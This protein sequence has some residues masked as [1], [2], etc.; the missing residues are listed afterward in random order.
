MGR[1]VTISDGKTVK[2]GVAKATT[3]PG[4]K[5]DKRVQVGAP[6]WARSGR[7]VR[8]VSSNVSHIKYDKPRKTMWV[9]FKSGAEYACPDFPYQT[10]VAYFNASSMGQYHW[11]LR[12]QGY[13]FKKM[14]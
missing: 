13:V 6:E 4:S 10:A 12:K 1:I 8:V 2:R 5:V 3:R 7:W 14:N 11:K 9:R